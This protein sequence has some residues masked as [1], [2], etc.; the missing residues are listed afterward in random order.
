MTLILA[1]GSKFRQQLMKDSGFIFESTTSNAPEESI[2][3]LPPSELSLARAR[4]KAH[5]VARRFPRAIVIG[6][7]SVLS[8]EGHGFDK[9]KS[10]DEAIARLVQ[11]AGRWHELCN[12][13][14]IACY[15]QGMKEHLVFQD[16]VRLKMRPLSREEIEAYVDLEPAW[17]DSV[18]C[19]YQEKVGIHLFE[20]IEG[21]HSSIIG[22]PLLPLIAALRKLDITPLKRLGS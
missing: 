16:R 17:K 11:M 3:D 18:A 15:D 7:D 2:R 9:A 20:E 8:F 19:Y 13:M 6:A 14:V 10:R 22:L 4:L 5:D 12:G 1:S 21:S